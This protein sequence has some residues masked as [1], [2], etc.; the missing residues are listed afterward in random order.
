MTDVIPGES[1]YLR[2]R[3]QPSL[4]SVNQLTVSSFFDLEKNLN[5]L[6]YIFRCEAPEH[7][8]YAV[9]MAQLAASIMGTE[10][11]PE[12]VAHDNFIGVGYI[13]LINAEQF[14]ELHFN[15]K[16]LEDLIG[17]V[18]EL[19]SYGIVHGNPKISF[20]RHTSSRIGLIGFGAEK[21]TVSSKFTFI[22]KLNFEAYKYINLLKE[23]SMDNEIIQSRDIDMLHGKEADIY[24]YDVDYLSYLIDTCPSFVAI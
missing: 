7:F 1:F 23:I 12:I 3:Q 20:L 19:L 15:P 8:S 10:F 11:Y 22:E 16:T 6:G 5:K 17:L 14:R 24:Q 18:K 13:I 2:F 4:T 21:E 9:K